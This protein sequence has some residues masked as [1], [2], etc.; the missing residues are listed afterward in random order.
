VETRVLQ[1][2]G[3]FRYRKM[4]LHRDMPIPAPLAALLAGK[5]KRLVFS[6]TVDGFDGTERAVPTGAGKVGSSRGAIPKAACFFR[7]H[8]CPQIVLATG[9][10]VEALRNE[11]FSGLAFAA[12]SK[13]KG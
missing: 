13:W 12:P 4:R 7:V 5:T 2:P 1:K 11:G 3:L 6:G 10:M 8:E 9:A